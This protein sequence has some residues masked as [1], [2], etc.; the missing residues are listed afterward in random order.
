MNTSG[1]GIEGLPDLW[2]Q[3]TAWLAQNAPEALPNLAPGAS[4][5][6][7]QT[8]ADAIEPSVPAELSALLSVNNGQRDPSGCCVLPG[9]E[10]LS[11][12]RIIEEWRQWQ[13]FRAGETSEG[14]QALDDYAHAL[15]VGVLDRYTHP[16]W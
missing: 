2:R 7:L 9:L 6:Q 5:E 4:A 16:G 1:S 10:F 3:Y 12:D 8:L 14:L 13:E 11:T 15:D